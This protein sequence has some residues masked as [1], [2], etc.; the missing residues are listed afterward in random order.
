[1]PRLNLASTTDQLVRPTNNFVACTST[2][3]DWTG[4]QLY[5]VNTG[6][7]LAGSIWSDPTYQQQYLLRYEIDIEF[8]QP[9]YTTS[10]PIASDAK[11]EERAQELLASYLKTQDLPGSTTGKPSDEEESDHK[12][13]SS[14]VVDPLVPYTDSDPDNNTS[15][16]TTERE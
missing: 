13:S 14:T 7:N 12:Y 5:I 6:G 3:I 10:P 15:P 1:V 2:T 4:F 9:T 11:V 8:K 16:W